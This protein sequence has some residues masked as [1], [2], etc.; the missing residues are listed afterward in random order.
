M[1]LSPLFHR[2]LL[3]CLLLLPCS[4][5]PCMAA[6]TEIID[7]IVAIV[8]DEVISLAELEAEGR[9][10]FLRLMGKIAPADQPAAIKQAR[11]DTLESMINAL[12]IRQQAT[13]LGINVDKA[14]VDRAIQG[15]IDKNNIS[16]EQLL[17]DLGRIGTTEP[18]YKKSIERQ[19]IEARLVNREV[20]SKVVVTDAMVQDH[21]DHH[22]VDQNA[23]AGYA[24][25]QMGFTWDEEGGSAAREEATQ[26]VERIRKLVLDGGDF[27][28]LARAHSDMPS[29]RNGGDIGT[30]S[31]NELTPYM[32]DAILPL[33]PGEISQVVDTEAGFQF[34]KLISV[35]EG[36][37]VAKAPLDAV[38]EEIR[39]TLY[40]QEGE[41]LYKAWIEQL[42]D[43]AQIKKML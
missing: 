15:I 5:L 36:G 14:E 3:L 40:E 19:I 2:T 37:V 30:F 23:P 33:N 35:N 8:N 34:F 18:E 42:Q 12:L 13:S 43:K 20:R 4:T 39:A 22:Y 32:H 25:L 6:E 26:R 28:E 31:T 38:K 21:Y 17:H 41:K 10:V 29:A 27:Q 9:P 7:R 1:T 16:R 11:R 24:L